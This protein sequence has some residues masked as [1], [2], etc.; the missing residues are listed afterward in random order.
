MA[1]GDELQSLTSLKVLKLQRNRIFDCKEILNLALLPR[2]TQLS[3]N[4]N[5]VME[6][7]NIQE[8][9][10]FHMQTLEVFN[11]MK[12]LNV[13]RKNAAK[14]F[15]NPNSFTSGKKS[16]ERR[17]DSFVRMAFAP[18]NSSYSNAH[19][20]KKTHASNDYGMGS[21]NA[22][23]RESRNLPEHY[24]TTGNKRKSLSNGSINQMDS[25]FSIECS[26]E[27]KGARLRARTQQLRQ[28][29]KLKKQHLAMLR[30]Q[31]EEPD[32]G[33]SDAEGFYTEEEKASSEE[34][35]TLELQL[36]LMQSS[37]MAGEDLASNEMDEVKKFL[38]DLVKEGSK[39]HYEDHKWSEV[40]ANTKAEGWIL[41]AISLLKGKLCFM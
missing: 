16:L 17:N 39:L 2:L 1:L 23:C 21:E 15:D 4:S 37:E 36:K 25:F 13:L 12:V 38:R 40:L 41:P 29:I 20:D 34:I 35:K 14:L 18:L 9:C 5:P 8:F 10:I 7:Q 3:I 28:I 6:S 33:L 24:R 22:V 32:S 19:C 27:N 31:M 30:K 26:A 11:D